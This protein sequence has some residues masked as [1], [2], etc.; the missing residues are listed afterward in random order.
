MSAAATLA[1]LSQRLRVA[2]R[3]LACQASSPAHLSLLRRTIERDCQ[4]LSYGG[5][6]GVA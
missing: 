4:P 1:E 2:E 6:A 3:I 5:R